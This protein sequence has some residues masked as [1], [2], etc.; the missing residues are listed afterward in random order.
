VILNLGNPGK[1]GRNGRIQPKR[2][3]RGQSVQFLDGQ[4]V[5]QTIEQPGRRMSFG[6]TGDFGTRRLASNS[7]KI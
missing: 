1:P 4:G 2:L 6:S 7:P 3:R 5:V